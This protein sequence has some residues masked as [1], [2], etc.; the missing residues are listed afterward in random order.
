MNT[1]RSNRTVVMILTLALGATLLAPGCGAKAPQEANDALTKVLT[2][3]A[4]DDVE[5]FVEL[6][7]PDQRE[8]LRDVDEM[9][10]F[11]AT[12]SHS[13]NNDSDLDVTDTSATIRVKLFF[14]DEEKNF[15]NVYFV[16]KKVEDQWLFDL[17]ETIKKEK[18]INPGYEFQI[19]QWS[20]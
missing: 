14:D 10:F 8:G 4:E 13:F 18:E 3:L 20:E 15:A 17:A 2:A 11:G 12:M 1:I 6:V 7:V 9:D 19:Y 16:M 5:G